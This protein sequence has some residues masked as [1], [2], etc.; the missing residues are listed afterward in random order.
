MGTGAGRARR[1]IVRGC[2][3]E[4]VQDFCEHR[5]SVLRLKFFAEVL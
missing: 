2:P 1:G 5:A 3:L 4:T